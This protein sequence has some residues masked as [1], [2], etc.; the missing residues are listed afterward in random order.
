[1]SDAPSAVTSGDAVCNVCRALVPANQPPTWR[2]DGF[3]IVRCPRCGLVFRRVLP[4]RDE[5]SEI[6]AESYFRRP[7]DDPGGQGYDDYLREEEL[8]RL[9]AVVRLRRLREHRAPG[10]LLDI[11]AA[12]GFFLDE[13]RRAGWTVEGIDV[14]PE[15]SGF[16]RERLGL[17]LGTGPFR[18]E[19]YEAGTYD[20]VT[21][22]DY[23]EHS[24]DPV[25]DLSSAWS[26]LRPGGVLALSTGDAS[27]IVARVSGRRWH[28]LTPEHH[29]FF[30]S[31]ATLSRACRE[32]GFEI[33]STSHPGARYSLRYL[34]YK[35]RSMAPDSAIVRRTGEAFEGSRAGRVAVPVNLWDIVTLLARRPAD[36]PGR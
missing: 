14:S 1:V 23:I 6:Y 22:W 12:A 34:T 29:N 16:G 3:D 13:A 11:G 4:T 10:R 21:M 15:M 30:F 27:S 32:A 25:A 5:L 7:A 2:K 28:L 17:D 24:I 9:N 35:L 36:G 26:L 18:V 8:H 33:V 19:E 31:T 20:C